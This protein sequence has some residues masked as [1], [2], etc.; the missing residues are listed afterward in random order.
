MRRSDY[1]KSLPDDFTKICL[2]IEQNCRLFLDLFSSAIMNDFFMTFTSRLKG[3]AKCVYQQ[4]N[5]ITVANCFGTPPAGWVHGYLHFEP[6]A[7]ICTKGFRRYLHIVTK[8]TWKFFFK[9]NQGT[10]P[11]MAFAWNFS[12]F[13]WFLKKNFRGSVGQIIYK[14]Y[15]I[16]SIS[17]LKYFL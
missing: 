1:R 6:G 13:F 12:G 10:C 9:F 16:Y 2:K 7:W 11:S 3:D 14:V 5:W 4:W 8:L 15:I 17:G